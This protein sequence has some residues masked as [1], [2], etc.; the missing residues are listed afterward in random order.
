MPG[1]APW[2]T[3]S[4]RL[5]V[6]NIDFDPQTSSFVASASEPANHRSGHG[7][8]YLCFFGKSINCG[9]PTSIILFPFLSVARLSLP[10]SS[11]GLFWEAEELIN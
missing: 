11:E 4:P 2:P 8:I 6:L 3:P 9:L 7:I 5:W 1:L 10:S